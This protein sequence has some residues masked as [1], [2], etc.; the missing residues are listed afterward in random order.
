MRLDIFSKD[1]FTKEQDAFLFN[2]NQYS[3]SWDQAEEGKVA[4]FQIDGSVDFVEE[5]VAFAAR[6]AV[7]KAYESDFAEAFPEIY[8]AEK[9]AEALMIQADAEADQLYAQMDQLMESGA[10]DEEMGVLFEKIDNQMAAVY[11]EVDAAFQEVVL[12]EMQT[13]VLMIAE[14]SAILKFEI[15][16]A[17]KTGM[18]NGVKVSKEEIEEAKEM[19][20]SL[21]LAVRMGK[22]NG[23]GNATDRKLLSGPNRYGW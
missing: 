22:A 19:V 5:K 8:Q 7:D 21:D 3:E 15:A 18:I 2:A 9:K 12:V 17:E 10:S 14:E 13:N 20:G 4:I 1:E 23:N 11:S 16:L 6:E